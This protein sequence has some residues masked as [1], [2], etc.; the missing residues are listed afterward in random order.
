M[1]KTFTLSFTQHTGT[2]NSTWPSSLL[3]QRRKG[4]RGRLSGWLGWRMGACWI[5]KSLSSLVLWMSCGFTVCGGLGLDLGGCVWCISDVVVWTTW[6]RSP[7]ETE[8]LSHVLDRPN[9]PGHHLVSAALVWSACCSALLCSG[10][11]DLLMWLQHS[12]SRVGFWP[13]IW[14]HMLQALGGITAH[15]DTPC[16]PPACPIVPPPT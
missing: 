7:L 2:G 16:Y 5:E 15:R 4:D 12:S 6:F 9:L 8:D 14:Y 1:L 10:L 13:L 11:W 3:L